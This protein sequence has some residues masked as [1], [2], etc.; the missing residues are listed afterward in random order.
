MIASQGA[1][2]VLALVTSVVIARFLGPFEVGLAAEALVFASL[3][4]VFVDFG[5]GSAIIQ[6]P[7]LTADDKS[8]AFW[9]GMA[10]GVALLLIGIGLSWP[11]AA[12]YG[13]PRVQPLFA[14]LSLAFLFTAPGVV[15]GALLTREMRFRSLQ[16]RTIIATTVSCVIGI[17]L[18]VAGAGPWAIVAQILT[19]TSASTALLWRA[20]PWRPQAIFS[21]DS[22]RS[23]RVYASHVFGTRTLEW[24]TANLDNFLVGRF[25]GAAPLGAYSIAY[26]LIITPVTRV[27]EPVTQVFFPAF[28]AMREPT[29]IAGAWLRATRILALVVAPAMFGLLVLAPDFVEVVFGDKW[30]AAV[31]V[32]QILSLVG[33]IRA[34]TAVNHGVLQS[35]ARTRVLFRFTVVLSVAT[36]AAFIAGLPWGIDGVATAYLTVTLVLQPIFL[37]LTT[38]AVGLS[39][40]DWLRSVAGVLEAAVGMLAVVFA[41][42]ELLLST[43]LG[44]GSRLVAVTALGA[45]VYLPLVAW[46]APEV[47]TEL[48]GVLR[49]LRQ[50]PSSTLEA[51]EAPL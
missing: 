46:R 26:S 29:R 15:Q 6:R 16:I 25:L 42:R 34:L 3:A 20:S 12:L 5:L 35:L 21:M 37:W 32:I 27:A 30:D 31:P 13:E 4:L 43:D 23:M 28:S 2:Q 14:V 11:I 51:T 18:A 44:A 7:N 40:R 36:V 38:R 41:A 45:L 1:T 33:L 9:A 24:G 10:L 22:L 19:I 17:S 50:P 8:T 39:V 48:R 47:G 49:R